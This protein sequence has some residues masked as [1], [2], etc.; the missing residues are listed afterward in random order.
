MSN[1]EEYYGLTG[2]VGIVTGAGCGIGKAIAAEFARFGTTVVCVDINRESAEATVHSIVQTGGKAFPIVCDISRSEEVQ[3]CVQLV[4]EREGN[5]DILVNNAGI[6]IRANAEEMTT[7]QWDRVME[8][9]LRGAF[10]FCREVGKHMIENNIAGR[11]INMASITG[12]VGVETGNINYASTKGGLIALTR[13]LA[14]EWAKHN[15]LVNAVAPS[16]TRTPLIEQLMIDKPEVETYFLGN[17][18]LGRLA[19]P[20]EIARPVVFLASKAASFITGHVLTVDGG[21]TAK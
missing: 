17:I 3:Q 21:H 20:E 5:I 9:N 8:V 15:I 6:G 4:I 11:I 12:L 18:P 7:E 10:L 16:H 19:R 13:T 2:K 1:I 14:I